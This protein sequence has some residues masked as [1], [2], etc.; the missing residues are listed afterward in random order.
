MIKKFKKKKTAFHVNNPYYNR[1]IISYY[2]D[3]I[4][5]KGFV[6]TDGKAPRLTIAAIQ[7]SGSHIGYKLSTVRFKTSTH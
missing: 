4:Y 6:P 5:W 7:M 2:G 1:T 3:G